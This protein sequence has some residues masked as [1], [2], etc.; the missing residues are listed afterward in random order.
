MI[1]LGFNIV[2]VLAVLP[3][4]Q[5]QNNQSICFICHEQRDVQHI[6]IQLQIVQREA[7]TEFDLIWE[8][9]LEFLEALAGGV[10]IGFD[11][12]REDIVLTLD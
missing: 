11:F 7:H 10:S 12:H 4:F 3:L 6:I 8:Q 1:L 5:C 9:F 2:P